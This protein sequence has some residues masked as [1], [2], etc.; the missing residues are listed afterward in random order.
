MSTLTLTLGTLRPILLLIL[1]LTL[2]LGALNQSE[3]ELRWLMIRLDLTVVQTHPTM[4]MRALREGAG[5]E[6]I[7]AAT[8]VLQ[9]TA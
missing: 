9:A 3:H 2:M 6:A 4:V 5:E 1:T 8:A 7:E